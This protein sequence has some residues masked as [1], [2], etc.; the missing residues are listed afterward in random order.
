MSESERE[1][2]E[3]C[4]ERQGMTLS[5]LTEADIRFWEN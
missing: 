1:F 4:A 5:E 2:L 3:E